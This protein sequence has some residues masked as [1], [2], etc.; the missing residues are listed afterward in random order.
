M[1]NSEHT[2]QDTDVSVLWNPGDQSSRFTATGGNSSRCTISCGSQGGTSAWSNVVVSKCHPGPSIGS[3]SAACKGLKRNFCSTILFTLMPFPSSLNNENKENKQNK[4]FYSMN[5][6]VSLFST[7]F[8]PPKK[9]YS[10]CCLISKDS[11]DINL[12]PCRSM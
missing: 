2:C 6:G 4:E 11:I 12:D 10:I 1:L 3:A 9:C 7:D 5:Q 8:N